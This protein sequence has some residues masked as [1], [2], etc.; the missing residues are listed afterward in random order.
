MQYDQDNAQSVQKSFS[1]LLAHRTVP[2]GVEPFCL[3]PKIRDSEIHLCALAV[4][5]RRVYVAPASSC[6]KYVASTIP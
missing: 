5:G 3:L 4:P 6:G 2:L 1:T